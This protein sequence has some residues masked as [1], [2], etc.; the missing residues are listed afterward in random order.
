MNVIFKGTIHHDAYG[1]MYHGG[2]TKGRNL[3]EGVAQLLLDTYPD[4]FELEKETE[5][6]SEP[7]V[8]TPKTGFTIETPEAKMP[9]TRNK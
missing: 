5:V 2:S 6:V 7:V 8:Q 9:K 4:L 3:P 1:T